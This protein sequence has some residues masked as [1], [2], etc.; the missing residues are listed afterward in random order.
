MAGEIYYWSKTEG[1]MN[2]GIILQPGSTVYIEYIVTIRGDGMPKDDF[3]NSKGSSVSFVSKRL[4]QKN[5]PLVQTTPAT[6]TPFDD[7][8]IPRY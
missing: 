4:Y 6:P 2:W 1:S 7:E 5:A 8:T 3:M